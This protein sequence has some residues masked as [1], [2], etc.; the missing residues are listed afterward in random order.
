M[1]EKP[2]CWVHLKKRR[3][4]EGSLMRRSVRRTVVLEIVIRRE[5]SNPFEKGLELMRLAMVLACLRFLI[6]VLRF[7]V[8]LG[9]GAKV[10][11]P[12]KPVMR[13]N[14]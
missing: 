2:F 11:E 5:E 12:S 4:L 13:K 10:P 7:G 1:W 14:K 9:V 8:V 3:A 6:W